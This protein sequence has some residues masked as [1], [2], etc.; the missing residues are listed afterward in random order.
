MQNICNQKHQFAIFYDF[1]NDI[2]VNQFLEIL[3]EA[4]YHRL[5]RVLRLTVDDTIIL[6]NNDLNIFAKIIQINRK[7]IIL[8]V[9]QVNVTK[10]LTPKIT[11]LISFLKKDAFQ[12]AIYFSTELGANVIQPI[13]TQK[14]YSRK[15]DSKEYAKLK[16]VIIN[17]AEV[18][19][20]YKLP[21]LKEPISIEEFLNKDCNVNSIKI[22]FDPNGI[23]LPMFLNEYSKSSTD[24]CLMIG[25]EG[26]LTPDEKQLLK[27]KDF[28]F[29]RLTPTILRAP[30]A[31]ALAIGIFRSFYISN[32]SCKS[33]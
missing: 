32:K 29:C 11:I 27:S 2:R 4:L 23:W 31:I 22:F 30:I 13:V 19:K 20:N 14:T 25:P 9:L 24:F 21:E 26:D 1:L 17:A 33:N 28:I 3:E 10:A 16:K 8:Q 12:E 15:F 18:S 5:I 7:S 6:F